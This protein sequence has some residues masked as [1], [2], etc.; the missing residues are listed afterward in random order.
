MRQVWAGTKI[1]APKGVIMLGRVVMP[2]KN[3]EPVTLEIKGAEGAR[4]L[5]NNEGKEVSRVSIGANKWEV[6][7]KS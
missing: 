2:S 1:I 7:P 5:T 3:T 4:V 6:E